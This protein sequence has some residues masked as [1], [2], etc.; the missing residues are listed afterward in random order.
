MRRLRSLKRARSPADD[1]RGDF[2]AE[3]FRA[4]GKRLEETQ[5]IWPLETHERC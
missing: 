1:A 5:S 4:D 2:G 3:R